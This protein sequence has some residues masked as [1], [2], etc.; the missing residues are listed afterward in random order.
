MLVLL[1]AG[2]QF[3]CSR[4]SRKENE[5]AARFHAVE[6]EP[7]HQVDLSKRQV[8]P[9]SVV[10][11]GTLDQKE[12]KAKVAIDP[13]V[14]EHYKGIDFDKLKAFRL[15]RPATGYVSYRIGDRIF[16]TAK[17][18]AFKP[19]EILLS[20]GVNVLRGRCGNRVSLQAKGPVQKNAE[21]SEAVLDAP[22]W[23][24]P[25]FQAMVR[26]ANG[27]DSGLPFVLPNQMP[28]AIA[29]MQHDLPDGLFPIAPSVLNSGPGMIGGGLP[30]GLS[31]GGQNE[32]PVLES[33][34][35]FVYI[36]TNPVFPP[37]PGII[38]NPQ[39]P[40]EFPTGPEPIFYV[41]VPSTSTS[42]LFMPGPNPGVLPPTVQPPDWPVFPPG[43]PF[44]PIYEPPGTPIVPEV[45]PPIV[46]PPGENPIPDAPPPQVAPVP[47]PGTLLLVPAA[48][49]WLFYLRRSAAAKAG[50]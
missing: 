11:G 23:D 3:A 18:L 32:S 8:F 44:P 12:V 1:V 10:P 38:I 31:S 30:G 42:V 19:G 22:S 26:E 4:E 43:A 16:W 13:V 25:V 46:V 39:P 27:Q 28:N 35:P 7:N 20:D 34:P 40:L 29:T 49:A 47:E 24:G 33:H 6:V 15:T 37:V 14:R 5:V 36:A 45:D 2:L 21:P 17:R 41:P 50:S 9:F 48:A